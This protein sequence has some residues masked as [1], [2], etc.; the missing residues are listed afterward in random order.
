MKL[1]DVIP[2][3]KMAGKE[4]LSYFTSQDIEP[5]TLV[6]VPLRSKKINALAVSV[7]NVSDAK[8]EIKNAEFEYKKVESIK[9][10][11]FLS[12]ELMEAVADTA[13]YFATSKGA[14]LNYFLPKSLIEISGKINFGKSSAEVEAKSKDRNEEQPEEKEKTAQ[15]PI[16]IKVSSLLRHAVQG[17]DEERISHHKSMIRQEF[18]KKKSVLLCVPSIEE[19]RRFKESLEKGIED[20]TFF[21]HGALSKKNLLNSIKKIQEEKH[22]ILIIANGSFLSIP[23]EDIKTIILEKENSRGYKIPFRPYL[24]IR[25]F[26]EFLAKRMKANFIVS[27]I[28]LRTET[29]W[30]VREGEFSEY[31]P[32][33]FR[34]LSTADE[35]LIDMRAYKNAKSTFKI[36][37]DETE[38]LIRRNKENNENM[39][40]LAVRRGLSPSTVCGDCQNIVTCNSCSSPVVLHKSKAGDKTFFLCHRC[41]ERRTA[42]E[43]CKV[44]G[45]WKLGTVGIGIDLVEEKIRDKFKEVKIWRIDSDTAKTEKVIVD[46][47]NKWRNSPGSVLIGTEMALHYIHEKTFNSAIVSMDSLFSLPDFRIHEKI[48]YTLLTIRH[49]TSSKFILQ[50][51]NPEEKV[52]EWALKGNLMDFYKNEVEQ[53]KRFNYPPFFTLIKITVTGEKDKIVKEMD[54]L[55]DFLS[56]YEMDIFPA[57]THTVKNDYVLHGLLRIKRENWP[58]KDLVTKLMA[59]PPYISIKVDPESLL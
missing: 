26:A 48:F 22:P 16:E 12:R 56:P 45:S 34:S 27:D 36:L 2:I 15:K 28:F 39:F 1:I 30:R 14:V 9:S 5:G 8:S 21:L 43:Y 52:L 18:A 49:I 29:L 33:K 17:D 23:R 46:T 41:G 54:S 13:E 6:E 38:A 19:G 10:K 3:A 31:A 37:S 25:V 11:K 32:F 51:R 59:L 53:R 50:T 44:C 47:L 57:F 55:R 35:K 42:E 20:Y 58:D 4:T 24:D 40:I 7:Q